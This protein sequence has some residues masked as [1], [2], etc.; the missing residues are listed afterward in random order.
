[1]SIKPICNCCGEEL[2]D[3]GAIILSPPYHSVYC[4]D[5]EHV[6]KWHICQKCYDKLESE[7][8]NYNNR[9]HAR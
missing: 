7:F 2:D 1:M 8:I 9:G 3:F 5:D 6:Y 4:S